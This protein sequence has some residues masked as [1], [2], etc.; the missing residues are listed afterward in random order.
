MRSSRVDLEV[1][2]VVV[3]RLSFRVLVRGALAESLH[4]ALLASS[5]IFRFETRVELNLASIVAEYSIT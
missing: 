3:S 4:K 1:V 2:V 5:L